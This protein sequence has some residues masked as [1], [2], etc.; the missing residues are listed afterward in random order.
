MRHLKVSATRSQARAFRKFA[1]N[2]GFAVFSES[3]REG[4]S[5]ISR[6]KWNAGQMPRLM[7]WCNNNL[8]QGSFESYQ[9]GI[10]S[11]RQ[12]GVSPEYPTYEGVHDAVRVKVGQEA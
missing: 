9:S 10:E 5:A 4:R 8:P 12:G 6:A 2:I 7:A 3:A 11:S 1:T